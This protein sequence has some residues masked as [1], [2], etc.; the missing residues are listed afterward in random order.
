MTKAE[1]LERL[2]RAHEEVS[3]SVARQWDGKTALNISI[4]ARPGHDTDMIVCGAIRDAIAWI[5]E[6]GVPATPSPTSGKGE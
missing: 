6:C 3:N 1:V 5:Q 2:G 4:P